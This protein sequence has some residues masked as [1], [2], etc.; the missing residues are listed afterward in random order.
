MQGVSVYHYSGTD[1]CAHGHEHH[2][3]AVARGAFPLGAVHVADAVVVDEY[4]SF[5]VAR[6]QGSA[7]HRA[8]GKLF[9]ARYVRIPDYSGFGIDD[10]RDA[11]ADS[12]DV[13]AVVAGALH[14]ESHV[15]GN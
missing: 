10:A 12:L 11:G 5:L 15:V 9:P 3:A 4:G 1:A 7:N 13:D 6:T 8:K 14:Q 2:V